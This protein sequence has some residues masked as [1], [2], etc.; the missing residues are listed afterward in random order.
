MIHVKKEPARDISGRSYIELLSILNHF[1]N[2][3]FSISRQKFI[4]DFLTG[5]LEWRDIQLSNGNPSIP[6]IVQA[7]LVN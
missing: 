2:A 5:C 7:A 4:V 1:E 6:H 3:F